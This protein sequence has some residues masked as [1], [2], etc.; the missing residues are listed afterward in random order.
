[1]GKTSK[2]SGYI[3]PLLFVLDL[4]TINV[5]AHFILPEHLS[6]IWYYIFITFFWSFVCWNIGFYEIYRYTK[7]LRI[8]GKLMWQYVI[9]LILNFAYIGF[10]WKFSRPSLIVLY[11]TISFLV[12]TIFKFLNYFFLRQ[13]SVTTFGGNL[14]R[15]VVLGNGKASEHLINFFKNNTDYGYKI[16]RIFDLKTNKAKQLQECYDFVLETDVDEIYSSLND[17][18]NEEVNELIDFADNNLKTLKFIPDNKQPLV[19]NLVYDYCGYIPVLSLRNIPLHKR[20]NKIVKRAFDIVF[21]LAVLVFILSWLTP[22]LALLIR[23]ESKGK[24]FFKQKRNG[25]NNKKFDCYKFRSMK[26]VDNSKKMWVTEKDNRVT[27]IGNFIRKTSIDELPQF[28]NVFKGDMSV[29]G[30]RPHPINHTEY[31]IQ[32]ANRF[33]ARHFIKPGITGLA[34]TSGCR[35]EVKTDKDIINR[36]RYDIFYME[37]WS[38][39]LDIKIIFM[40]VYNALKGDKKAY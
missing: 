15:V 18:N 33:M 17:I 26:C 19:R 1:M 31:Y 28:W 11:V 9:F 14:R 5:L 22:I 34:Q 16:E 30:P 40:T 25:L 24:V 39:A 7:V 8:I 13:Y 27:A 37:N 3:R 32:K 38:F 10:F 23:L 2:Y 29:V 12:I 36:L 20:S 21:S 6:T 4:L 35:G